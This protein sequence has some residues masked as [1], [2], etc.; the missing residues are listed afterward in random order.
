MDEETRPLYRIGDMPL[1]ERPREKLERL[2]AAELEPEELLAILLRVG[3][4][5]ESAI[6]VGRRLLNTLGGI[7]G[8]HQTPF[9]ELCKHH[10]VG[11]AKAAQIKAALEL[12]D[13]MN[14]ERLVEKKI[15]GNPDAVARQVA[16]RVGHEMSSLRQENLWVILL[17][18]RSRM[19]DIE[20]L[21][22]GT[23][24]SSNVRNAEIF[25]GAIAKNAASVILV[26]NHPSGDP[27]PSTEDIV[28]TRGAIEAGKQLE[29][30]VV[31]HVVIG[32]TNNYV[33]LKEK[34]L[35]FK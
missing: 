11:K 9:S 10:G 31:D 30:E 5:G 27:T 22:Q 35:A 20:K 26:H 6:Q 1:K 4:K 29:I 24:Y 25:R 15:I 7:S 8:I 17:D 19:I 34:G 32:G 28:F 14:K 12:G 3:V 18:I 16:E 13:K 33:S 23:L 21:Y 2:G